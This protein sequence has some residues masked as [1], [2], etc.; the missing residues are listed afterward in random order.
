MDSRKILAYLAESM[1]NEQIAEAQKIAW[2]W[3]KEHAESLAP[4]DYKSLSGY[5][6]IDRTN[7]AY[8]VFTG[9]PK[10]ASEKR[11][12]ELASEIST[13]KNMQMMSWTRFYNSINKLA[14]A[15]IVKHEYLQYG[16]IDGIACLI[17]KSPETPWGLTWNGGIAL[18]QNDYR[19]AETSYQLYQED[20][21]KHNQRGIPD[22]RGDPINPA[23]HLP[24]FGCY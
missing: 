14:H 5:V 9:I 1:T 23:G 4:L 19:Q 13:N 22:P 15:T 2:A 18:T 16:V 7:P 8:T 21:K 6:I 17:G 10:D 3:E 12:D 24:A 20:P 11:I